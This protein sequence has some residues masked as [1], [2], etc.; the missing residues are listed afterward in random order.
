[1]FEFATV[2]ASYIYIYMR[3]PQIEYYLK[4]MFLFSEYSICEICVYI[5]IRNGSQSNSKT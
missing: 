3:N 4:I 2:A 5:Y 1:M